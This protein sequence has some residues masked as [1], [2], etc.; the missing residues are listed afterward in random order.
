M[1]GRS[2]LGIEVPNRRRTVIPLGR[3]VDAPEFRESESPLTMALGRTLRG[4][5]YYADLT[6][7]PPL[8]V[9]GATG[10]GTRF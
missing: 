5:P 4:E 3:L 6:K 1:P 9:A 8:L 2:T 7:M 10:A